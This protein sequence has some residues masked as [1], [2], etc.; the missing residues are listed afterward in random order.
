MGLGSGQSFAGRRKEVIPRFLTLPSTAHKGLTLRMIQGI[1]LSFARR[2]RPRHQEE[3]QQPEQASGSPA[4][5]AIYLGNQ[6]PCGAKSRVCRQLF[7]EVYGYRKLDCRWDR[8]VPHRPG[9]GLREAPCLNAL[10][11][12]SSKRWVRIKSCPDLT[13]GLK[14]FFFSTQGFYRVNTDPEFK[15]TGIKTS[16]LDCEQV[17][18]TQRQH[19]NPYPYPKP[20]WTSSPETAE[21]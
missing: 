19:L 1:A 21:L 10:E 12:E 13:L 3:E 7:S 2:P 11:A 18:P 15:I 4:A 20:T 16:R 17:P 6:R 5:V 14:L 8:C 9:L